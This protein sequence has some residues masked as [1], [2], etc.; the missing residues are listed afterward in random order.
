MLIELMR[1]A[2]PDMARRW[3]ACLLCAPES[4]RAALLAEMEARAAAFASQRQPAA[5]H[6]PPEITI[7]HPPVQHD[8]YTEQVSTIY[9]R[10][11]PPAAKPARRAAD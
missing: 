4:E 10:S 2:G 3:L 1:P 11:E 7:L 5:P 8:G 6:T 9:A